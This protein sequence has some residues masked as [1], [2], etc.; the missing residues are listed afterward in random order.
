MDAAERKKVIDGV[1][2][3]LKEYYVEPATRAADGRCAEH[4]RRPRAT[5]MRSQMGMRL[6]RD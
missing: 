4:A 3:D 6:R 5:M 2:S 1:N